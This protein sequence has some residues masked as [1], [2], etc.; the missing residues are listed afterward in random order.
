MRCDGACKSL[1]K[2]K[3]TKK[4][5]VDQWTTAKVSWP[6]RARPVAKERGAVAS[7]N[8]MS[9]LTTRMTFKINLKKQRRES[10]AAALAEPAAQ[11]AAGDT[12][13]L[14][15]EALVCVRR[16]PPL[17]PLHVVVATTVTIPVATRHPERVDDRRRRKH[18]PSVHAL[19]RTPKRA[20]TYSHGLPEDTVHPC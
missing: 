15:D 3:K 4:T 6:I 8:V 17:H 2:R 9:S 1:W 20:A 12:A 5:I 19:R 14:V 18:V 13:A 16:R 7:E 11:D 10:A